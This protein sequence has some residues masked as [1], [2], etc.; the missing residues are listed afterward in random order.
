MND[1]ATGNSSALAGS[2]SDCATQPVS[3]WR[4]VPV[5]T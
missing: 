1:T 4:P 5:I 3:A 2:S